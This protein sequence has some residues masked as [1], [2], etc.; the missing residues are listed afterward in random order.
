MAGAPSGE[1]SSETSLTLRERSR[2][3]RTGLSFHGLIKTSDR[4][5]D[6]RLASGEEFLTHR[7]LPREQR[8]LPQRPAGQRG[9]DARTVHSRVWPDPGKGRCLISGE[10]GEKS[11]EK[12]KPQ[13]ALCLDLQPRLPS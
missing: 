13:E 10:Q 9:P 12:V 7:T 11:P 2:S 6:P 3:Q 4:R 5:R 8:P 1:Q